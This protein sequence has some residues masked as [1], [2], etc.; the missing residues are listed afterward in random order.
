M[1]EI[2]NISFSYDKDLVLQN[3]VFTVENDK[4]VALMGESGCG[5][6]TLLKLIYGLYDLDQG[7]IRYNGKII[8]GPK[9]NLIAGESYI[10]YMSQDFDLMPY[11][12]VAENVGKF[13]S[14]SNK[15]NKRSRIHELL[16]MVEMEEF[17]NTK[18]QFLSGGQM[19]RVALARTLAVEPEV[20][21][22]DEPFSQIDTFRRN[23]LSRKLFHYL[24]DKGITC[25][26]ATHDSG[27]VLSF[28][29]E[30]LIL[31]DGKIVERATP[32]G[33]FQNPKNKYAASLFD[34]VNEIPA[35]YFGS[36]RVSKL[37]FPHQLTT[38]EF[39]PLMVTIKQTYFRGSHYLVEAV[40]EYGILFFENE[41]EM[42]HDTIAYLKIKP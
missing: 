18:A 1:L 5:K 28:S 4:N 24:K 17:A 7:E 30:I 31:K 2:D 40:Y 37:V 36:S 10:K 22:L 12:T 32:I 8:S 38:T 19:Q 21:L 15:E 3:L 16:Q 20:L 35:E 6:S 14:N 9:S 29:D 23:S 41:I 33:M 11:I 42:H 34:D 39:S 25:I 27:E 26:F 13:I